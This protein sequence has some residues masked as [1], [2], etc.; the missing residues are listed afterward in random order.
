MHGGMTAAL[1][2]TLAWA[3]LSDMKHIIYQSL[4][5]LW[6]NGRFS[7]WDG[8]SLDYVK[9]LG[10]D[11]LWLTGIPR[12]AAGKDF[13]KGTAGSPYA[14][15]DWMDT[16]P[17]LADIP[18][19]RMREFKL[20][21]RRAHAH[22]LKII[23]DYIPNHVARDYEG[24]IP[25][26]QYC[27]YD[28][29]DTVKVDWSDPRTVGEMASVLRF[30][31]AAGVDGF[32]CDMVQMVPPD[33]L[34][35]AIGLARSAYPGL[36]FIAEV[37][38]LG[39]YRMYRDAGMDLLYDKD[40]CYDTLRSI[41]TGGAPAYG[42]TSQWQMIGDMQDCMLDFL[43]N[44]DEQRVAASWGSPYPWA[45]VA[46]AALFNRASFM[47]YSGQEAGENA[48]EGVDG[49]TSIFD[50]C[51][52]ASLGRLGRSLGARTAL[53]PHEEDMLHRYRS[54][55]QLAA[56]PVFADGGNWDLCY[57]QG[58]DGGFDPAKHF[59]FL[60][61][62]DG[63]IYAVFCNFSREEARVVLNL[64][65]EFGRQKVEAGAGPMDF[66]V[67]ELQSLV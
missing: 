32:R 49:R 22:G 3:I 7:S 15:S 61:Y 12:H 59:A 31:A 14:V 16:N 43:E 62:G 24:T 28:W 34:G 51:K 46:Y 47:L 26:F 54:I 66:A 53:L 57:C 8:R 44:H 5:R 67:A 27:D 10:A 60:R 33:A 52:P 50:W 17:Y 23:I 37:Y 9:S 65:E 39:N 11:I 30:W 21:V 13:V 29:T 63:R 42:L 4:A 6:R 41:C 19:E 2:C 1:P 58:T 56:S 35:Q 18:D 64:P 48:S 55:L 20:L 38:G 36:M 45:A 40:G 25:H